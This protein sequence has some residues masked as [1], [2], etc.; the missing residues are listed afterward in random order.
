MKNIDIDNQ[1]IEDHML[2]KEIRLLEM[3]TVW[4]SE[5]YIEIMRFENKLYYTSTCWGVFTE[6]D[7][8]HKQTSLL[9]K[10]QQWKKEQN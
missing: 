6:W 4:S 10:S 8:D 5:K 2:W 1:S 9:H 7:I 3:W